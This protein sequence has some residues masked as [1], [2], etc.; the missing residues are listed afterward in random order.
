MAEWKLFDGDQAHVSTAEFH[1]HRERAPHLEQSGHRDRLLTA[2]SFVMTAVGLGA[3]SASDL[4]CGD[5][6]LLSLLAGRVDAWGYDFQPSNAAGW[7]EREIGR[8]HV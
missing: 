4:G 5:G 8:A 1:A 3:R 7:A 2:A 6:G